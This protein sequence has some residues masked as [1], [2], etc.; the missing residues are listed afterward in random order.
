MKKTLVF[1][2]GLCLLG[3]YPLSAADGFYE[4]ATGSEPDRPLTAFEASYR[5]KDDLYVDR[6]GRPISGVIVWSHRDYRR[7]TP[8]E[9][10]KKNG[11][12][13][14]WI[15]GRLLM[16]RL[17]VA[18]KLSGN[19]RFY[20]YEGRLRSERKYADPVLH[21]PGWS[22]EYNAEGQIIWECSNTLLDTFNGCNTYEYYPNGLIKSI[23]PVIIK[24]ADEK[25]PSVFFNEQG[26]ILSTPPNDNAAPQV[27]GDSNRAP[28]NGLKS[29]LTANKPDAPSDAVKIY[30]EG[31]YK[32]I[33]GL[34]CDND[35]RPLTGLIIKTG[36]DMNV[37]E[38]FVSAG[39]K[40]G[41]ELLYLEGDLA[42]EI[43]YADGLRQGPT[44][45]FTKDGRVRLKMI[46]EK[47][48]VVSREE[49][50]APSW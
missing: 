47:G 44:S 28:G 39:K 20:D 35:G 40:E 13:R 21:A 1:A 10:G 41:A 27:G 46:Y 15:R 3:S 38:S 4:L 6:D 5:E 45:H 31:Q 50:V 9:N 16:E 32:T 22:R 36:L 18:N 2:L 49:L 12:D 29:P 8:V 7:E 42:T 17:F 30:V 33:E 23:K 43:F 37:R 14:S 26:L 34:I 48:K 11:H 24:K 19:F 25:R